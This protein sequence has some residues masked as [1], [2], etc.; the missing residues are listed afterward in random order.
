MKVFVVG[1]DVAIAANGGS[2]NTASC[3]CR[4]ICLDALEHLVTEG[5]V[6]FDD[7]EDML[8]E[9][10]KHLSLAGAPGVG[11]MFFKHLSDNQWTRSPCGSGSCWR[12]PPVMTGEGSRFKGLP[13]NA[14]DP[15]DRKFL[16]VAVVAKAVVLNATDSDWEEHAPFT[17]DLGVVANQLC[18]DFSRNRFDSHC[19]KTRCGTLN[20]RYP[21]TPYWP[22]SPAVGRK[23]EVHSDPGRFVDVPVVVNEKLD[24]RQQ[25]SLAQTRNIW[26]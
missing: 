5:T 4:R 20:W 25:H 15:S 13:P 7:Q 16:A 6:A 2:K 10:R 14:F 24:G 12:I 19:L 21:R 3:R 26:A 1:S 18:P 9:Y 22:H 17:E 23:D 11:E 8:K